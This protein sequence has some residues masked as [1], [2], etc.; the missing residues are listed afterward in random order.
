MGHPLVDCLG[1]MC[2]CFFDVQKVNDVR[3]AF[4]IAHFRAT[5]EQTKITGDGTW[6]YSCM[7]STL[8][9]TPQIYNYH[10]VAETISV[11][12]LCFD[13]KIFRPT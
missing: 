3:F 4:G 6:E 8:I 1:L 11:N 9:I 7:G 13:V 2:S 5:K 10:V 12:S